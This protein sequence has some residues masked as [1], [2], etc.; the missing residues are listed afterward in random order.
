MSDAAERVG[1]SGVARAPAA[2]LCRCYAAA[3]QGGRI[4]HGNFFF[5]YLFR[6]ITKDFVDQRQYQRRF[7]QPNTH[8]ATFF[9]IYKNIIPLHRSNF[10]T[11]ANFRRKVFANF[12]N[13]VK[14]VDTFYTSRRLLHQ[15]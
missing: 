9:E 5:L 6:R 2:D 12:Q 11:L 10:N 8:F 1:A 14:N 15:V 3:R 7:L 4:I 13:F